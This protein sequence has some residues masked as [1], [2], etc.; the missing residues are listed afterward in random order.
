V[1][2]DRLYLLHILE[3]IGRI[4]TYIEGGRQSFMESTIVQ[5]AVLRNLH[6]LT[7][8]TQRL[9]SDLK[10]KHTE[11][12]WHGIAGFRNVLVHGY[13]GVDEDRCWDVIHRLLPLLKG[14]VESMLEE[15][16]NK[17]ETPG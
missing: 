9:S 14:A 5:D 12:D 10:A 6:T 4:E 7:E 1:R 15:C 17:R 3:C 13:L 2:D 11:V 16:N 8:S